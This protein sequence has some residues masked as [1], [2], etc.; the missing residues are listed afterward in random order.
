MFTQKNENES[1]KVDRI[2]LLISTIVGYIAVFIATKTGVLN[3][4]LGAIVLIF[5]YMYLN[6]NLTNIF[7]VSKRTTF[8]VYI[9]MI[10]EI[11]YFF[12]TAFTLR[13]IVI[14][15]IGIGILSYLIIQ[16]EGKSE[17]LKIYRFLGIYTIIKIIFVLTWI[18]F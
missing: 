7:F 1:N 2:A 6:F 9:F 10:L 11:M 16:D 8:K 18:V 4:Y 3:P 14:Y 12:M 5:L 17:A 15:F 13:N